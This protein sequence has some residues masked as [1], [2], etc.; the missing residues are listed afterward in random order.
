MKINE[1]AEIMCELLMGQ[2]GIVIPFKRGEY[3]LTAG[4][5]KDGSGKRFLIILK[6]DAPVVP[7]S[8]LTDKQFNDAEQLV[9]IEFDNIESLDVFERAIA[10]LKKSFTDASEAVTAPKPL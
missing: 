3:G 6:L 7:G 8:T 5:F 9:R 10:A 4:H 2:S 1:I